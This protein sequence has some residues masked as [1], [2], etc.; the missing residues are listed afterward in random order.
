MKHYINILISAACAVVIGI[1]ACS[2]KPSPAPEVSIKPE[3]LAKQRQ[4]SANSETKASV[5]NN[6]TEQTGLQQPASSSKDAPLEGH[7]G[8]SG[9]KHQIEIV[10]P[11]DVK[12]KWDSVKLSI[13]DKKTNASHTVT[14][15]LGAEY[16]IPDSSISVKPVV[17]LPD[18]K[19]DSLTITSASTQLNNPAVN[20]IISDSGTGTELFKGWLY[21]KYPDV[22]PF[23][24]D[25]F[26][27]VML[28]GVMVEG[29]AKPIP[30][31]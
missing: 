23:Q 22:H 16:R 20:V 5:S 9:E 14:V 1:S 4:D 26:A 11:D 13:S 27:V 31:K 28:E 6:T 30:K 3:T 8:G 2:D 10:V 7:P 25:R 17:F 19:M 15:K 29:S 12:G 18:F 21:L 24:H